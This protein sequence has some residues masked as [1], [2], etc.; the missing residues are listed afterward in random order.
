GAK[1]SNVKAAKDSVS[2]TVDAGGEK[3][4][5]KADIVLVAAG[6]APVVDNLG[7]K[8]AGVQLNDRGFIK[9]NEKMET[10]AK[11][12]Y[13]IGDVAGPPML[14]HKGEHEGIICVEAIKGL[15]PHP[16]DKLKIPGCTYCTPQIASVGLTEAAAK[17]QG[18]E[19]RVGR[20]PFAG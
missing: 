7:L 19:I 8:E 10:S 15:D 3:K 12:I 6:R 14:A 17:A 4:E 11:G 2:M 20:F 16:I 1:I 18:R 13:A 9:I 5:L